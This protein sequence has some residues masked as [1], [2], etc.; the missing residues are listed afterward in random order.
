MNELEYKQIV[1]NLISPYLK[2]KRIGLTELAKL[3]GGVTPIDL[4]EILELKSNPQN[5]KILS[6]SASLNLEANPL[7]F[8]WRFDSK[9]IDDVSN[10]LVQNHSK[11]GCFG[12]PSVFT[13]LVKTHDIVLFD[14]NPFLKDEFK[15]YEDKIVELDINRKVIS[16]FEFDAIVMD[17]PWYNDYYLL[18][19][20]QA[21]NN[22]K[23][24]G[25]IYVS[26]YPSL[27]RPTAIEDWIAIQDEI[28][29]FLGTAE[30]KMILTYETPV[31]ENETLFSLGFNNVGNWRMAELVSYE[32]KHKTPQTLILKENHLWKRYRFG[33]MVVSLIV[34]DE[35][36]DEIKI[37]SPYSD[38]T[39]TLKSVSRRH[40]VRN[41]IN[42]LTSRNQA[43][44][45]RGTKKV[46][47]FLQ[48]LNQNQIT[49]ELLN[50][51]FSKEE[52]KSL[53]I[54]QSIIG[55]I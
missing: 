49:T 29:N 45:I 24:G 12:V 22:L 32:L 50:N 5:S 55:S 48:Y 26:K 9:T 35:D 30:K 47:V 40:F 38:G 25:K 27:L 36:C 46:D 51:K 14:I 42:F 23:L 13:K 7:D 53:N 18:W 11:I 6:N 2:N 34:Q 43:L 37:S 16:G 8:D 28:G 17:P 10:L 44:I 54:I 1:K 52:L 21:I 4:V 39:Y 33:N 31:F 41:R 3:S 19:F 20:K 15:P